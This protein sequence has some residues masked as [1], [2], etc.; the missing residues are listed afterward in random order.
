[1]L[2]DYAGD[3]G[4]SL[5]HLWL[6]QDAYNSLIKDIQLE[7]DPIEWTKTYLLGMVSEVDEILRN[8]QWKLHKKDNP[9]L[10]LTNI[11][12]EFADLTKYIFSLWQ[13]WGF[14]PEQMLAFIDLKSKM[15]HLM[16]AQESVIL[17]KNIV[18]SD[19]DGVLADWRLEIKRWFENSSSKKLFDTSNS[20][21]IDVDLALSYPEYNAMKEEFESIGGYATLP[22]YIDG[23]KTI[24]KLKLSNYSFVASTARPYKQYERIWL[25]TYFWLEENEIFPHILQ[26]SS[27]ERVLFANEL[28]RLGHHVILLEDNPEIALRAANTGIRVYVKRQKYNEYLNHENIVI[29]DDLYNLIQKE[30]EEGYLQDFVESYISP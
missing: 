10:S 22:A 13:V 19:I 25:D 27:F 28:R 12:F 1:M 7:R 5:R 4:E 8:I 14:S 18:I 23:I 17:S 9:K 11:G 21:L 20:L 30:Q 16:L 2:Q 6:K 24:K 3:I 26:M 15:L 29:L